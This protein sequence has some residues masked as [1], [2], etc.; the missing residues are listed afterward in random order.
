MFVTIILTGFHMFCLHLFVQDVVLPVFLLKCEITV[1][2]VSTV[3]IPAQPSQAQARHKQHQDKR[4]QIRLVDPSFVEQF[5]DEFKK[6]M[7]ESAI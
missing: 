2:P 6:I 4:R 5:V 3:N 7:N 1:S